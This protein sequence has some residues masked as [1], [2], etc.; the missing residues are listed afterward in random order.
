MWRFFLFY[1]YM[2]SIRKQ[3][4]FSSL[5]IYAGFGIGA[6]NILYLFPKFFT[7]EQFGLTRILM[8]ISMIL[9][10]VCAAGIIPTALKFFPF[11]K[12]YLK[13]SE[14]ELLTISIGIAVFLSIIVFL[15]MPLIEPWIIL[16]FA[17]KSPILTEYLYL[18]FPL[19][20]TLV[21]FNILEVFA[22]ISGRTVLSTFLREFLYRLLI[23]FLIISWALGI[24]SQ[25]E[26][27][28][29]IYSISYLP[30]IVVLAIMIFKTKQFV[31]QFRLSKVSKRLGGMMFKFGSAYFISML[32][33]VL[34][35][36][37]DTLIIASQSSGGL[38]DAAVFTIATYLITLMDVPQR[39]VIGAAT[40][41]ISQAWKDR[42]MDKLER[43]YK[44]TALNLLI[45]ASGIMGLVLIN[46]QL[47]VTFLG[48]QYSMLP[49]LILLLGI[50]KLIDLG[51]GLNSQILQLSKHW[52]IDL[53]TNIFFVGISIV[54]NFFL[55][56]SYGILGTAVGTIISIFIY[57]V[58]RLIFIKLIYNLQPFSWKNG[59][60]LCSAAFLT[61]ILTYLRISDNIMINAVAASILF[62]FSFSFIILKF[63]ISEDI[64]ELFIIIKE[65]LKLR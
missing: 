4:I 25:F 47:V 17:D 50:S 40:P 26:S 18:I 36:T 21:G 34:A 24:I 52:K 51:T 6:I 48:D 22:W 10:T 63:K 53:T 9:S 61:G 65:R 59:V 43:I 8:D 13:K 54:L 38:A 33:N 57:N 37:N 58:T 62:I 46:N 64:S 56:R 16:K 7:P 1:Q 39:G 28:I 27:F 35:K 14:N 42:D 3:S 20:L 45:I 19:T 49:I 15:M 5:F 55:T 30:V 31:I 12:K 44:K 41:H 60:T 23:T 11:Y 2:G 29:E 32:F